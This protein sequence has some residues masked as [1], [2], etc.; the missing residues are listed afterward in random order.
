MSTYCIV[1]RDHLEYARDEYSP[2][3]DT[4]MRNYYIADDGTN[5]TCNLCK[6]PIK[7][8]KKMDMQCENITD[9]LS[10]KEF[11]KGICPICGFTPACHTVSRTPYQ[12][13][14]YYFINPLIDVVKDSK[15][16][17]IKKNKKE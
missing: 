7:E 17:L 4:A 14:L 2:Q 3:H 10:L 9:D 6:K 16:P 11:P 5:N 12:A 13:L 8:H 15:K 1:S